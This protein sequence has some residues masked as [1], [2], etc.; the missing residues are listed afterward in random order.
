MSN[1]DYSNVGIFFDQS[2]N[3]VKIVEQ[4]MEILGLKSSEYLYKE[5]TGVDGPVWSGNCGDVELY[6]ESA[7]DD[8]LLFDLLNTLFDRVGVYSVYAQGNSVLDFYSGKERTFDPLSGKII[9]REFNYCYGEGTAF[10]KRVKSEYLSE[11]GSHCKECDIKHN[12]PMHIYNSL[13]DIN[14]RIA[15]SKSDDYF[16]CAEIIAQKMK[17]LIDSSITEIIIEDGVLN[18]VSTFSKEFVIPGSVIQIGYKAFKDCRSLKSVTIPEGVT[19]IGYSAFKGCKSLKSVTIPDSVK[20]ID[21]NA[22]SGCM[23]L[24]SVT[25]P[26]GVTEIGYLAFKGCT[27]LQSVTI[28]DRVK[29]IGDLAFSGCT[30]LQSV[31]IPEGVKEI[32][33]DVFFGCNN[34]E[35]TIPEKLSCNAEESIFSGCKTVYGY[36]G[37]CCTTEP[38][39]KEQAVTSIIRSDADI[40]HIL[41]YQKAKIWNPV[42]EKHVNSFGMNGVLSELESVFASNNEKKAEFSKKIVDFVI[43]NVALLSDDD[44]KN[45]YQFL[46]RNKLKGGIKAIDADPFLSK[47][48]HDTSNCRN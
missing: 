41:V 4:V 17:E 25:M 32:G 13:N 30:S 22:F 24:Q 18:S 29:T 1:W 38:L 10:G 33:N 28:P 8:Q 15:D 16:E 34:L 21:W 26:E 46:S 40:A 6:Y 39:P 37:K 36:E 31:T 3:N 7:E 20:K 35:I 48:V 12:N 47:R 19:E 5:D 2:K 23:S 44:L 11:A 42:V 14:E 43:S 9:V 27:S 45:A